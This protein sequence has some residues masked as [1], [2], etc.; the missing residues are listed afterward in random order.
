[1]LGAVVCLYNVYMT[2]KLGEATTGHVV[3]TGDRHVAPENFP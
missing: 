3:D 1:M 2:A